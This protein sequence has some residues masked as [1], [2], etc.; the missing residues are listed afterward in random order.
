MKPE[1]LDGGFDYSTTPEHKTNNLPLRWF[2]NW[3]NHLSSY[4]LR[5]ALRQEWLVEDTPF[6]LSKAGHRW[7]KLYRIIDIPYRRWGT[8]YLLKW[9]TDED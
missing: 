2:A 6:P 5:K 8:T 3:C 7:W 9:S 1:D 4:P